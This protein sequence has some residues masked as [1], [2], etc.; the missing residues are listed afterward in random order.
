MVVFGREG[1]NLDEVRQV[2][3]RPASVVDR[4]LDQ[5]FVFFDVHLSSFII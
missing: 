2:C 1:V 5:L 4:F 3:C